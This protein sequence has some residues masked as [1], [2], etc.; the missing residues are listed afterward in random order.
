MT[1]LLLLSLTAFLS[2]PYYHRM[3]SFKL[4]GV[5]SYTLALIPS[6]L[7]ALGIVKVIFDVN[8][9]TFVD[10]ASL[11]DLLTKVT[12]VVVCCIFTGVFCWLMF[13][14]DWMNDST[15]G[16]SADGDGEFYFV[17]FL[18]VVCVLQAFFVTDFIIKTIMVFS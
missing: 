14:A 2:W 12:F 1:Y 15:S 4:S 16:W 7:L 17:I 5:G 18:F 11:P 3:R 13:T 9:G 8:N 10:F 6:F